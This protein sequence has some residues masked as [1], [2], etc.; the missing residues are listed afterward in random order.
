M[1]SI[2]SRLNIWLG[3]VLLCL[4]FLHIALINHLPKDLIQDYVFSQLAVDGEALFSYL[5]TKSI[6]TI[7]KDEIS[8]IV[9][10]THLFQISSK[11]NIIYSDTSKKLN[12]AFP[13][14]AKN[15]EKMLLVTDR[16]GKNLLVWLKRSL[17]HDNDVTILLAQDMSNLH[18]IIHQRHKTYLIGF[19]LSILLFILLQN[20]LIRKIIQPIDKAL[21]ELCEIKEAKRDMI[22][23]KV[24]SEF[25]PLVDEINKLL[26]INKQ[27][28]QRSR[29]VSGNL[30]HALK[31]PL[32]VLTQLTNTKDVQDKPELAKELQHIS[33]NMQKI[34]NRELKHARLAGHSILGEV[35]DIN[36]EV[37]T[38]CEVL[39]KI[40]N[41]KNVSIKLTLLD[42]KISL[43]ADREDILELFGN[44]IDN[45][46]KWADNNVS[47]RLFY[48]KVLIVYIEDDGKG[49]DASRLSE[50]TQ[51]GL[52]LDET[53]SGHGLGLSIVTGIVKQYNGELH[54]SRSP[55]LGGLKV[56][57]S[58]DLT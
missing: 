13:K 52:R 22:E 39:E 34:I 14:I 43:Q 21:D 8:A 7:K 5:S 29:N 55:T 24:P 9:G 33:N 45:A 31:T 54:F 6:N 17:I 38:L 20:F 19:S 51:R 35:I 44:L 11:K 18:K 50:L 58:L 53:T 27:R 36:T 10:G 57:V 32:T 47:V 1:S 56:D 37:K 2:R 23:E 30:A 15:Q 41:H 3:I 42:K 40:Y 25:Q 49:V 28:L 46:C 16:K 4:S 48:K 26:K 12:I